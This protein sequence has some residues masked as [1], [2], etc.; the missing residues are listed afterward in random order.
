MSFLLLTPRGFF[1]SADWAHGVNYST[2][3][4]QG[5]TPGHLLLSHKVFSKLSYSDSRGTVRNKLPGSHRSGRDKMVLSR[6]S[7]PVVAV[8]SGSIPLPLLFLPEEI[9][10]FV[11]PEVYVASLPKA[12]GG[13]ASVLRMQRK[14]KAD[15]SAEGLITKLPPDIQAL[16][17]F[18]PLP[19]P[20][21]STK[22]SLLK[23]SLVVCFFFNLL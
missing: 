22:T 21:C 5:S 18:R 14:Q 4:C 20:D 17:V 8:I 2:A 7:L 12:R 13:D 16:F 15:N 11:I 10:W 23:V 9:A 6:A 1:L 19:I 3:F